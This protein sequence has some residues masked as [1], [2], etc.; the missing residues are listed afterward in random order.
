MQ[1]AQP[2]RSH[3]SRTISM[4]SMA[5]Y[6]SS[7]SALGAP[8]L[9][10]DIPKAPP[11]LVTPPSHAHGAFTPTHSASEALRYL[12]ATTKRGL[13]RKRRPVPDC[14][15]DSGYASSP[16]IPSFSRTAP[17]PGGSHSSAASS[18]TTLLDDG[19]CISSPDSMHPAKGL[20]AHVGGK[21]HQ[22]L[23]HK[24]APPSRPNQTLRNG[25][26]H[27]SHRQ[28]ES[29]MHPILARLER[30]S[31]VCAGVVCATC[32]CSGQGFP[33]CP[34][35]SQQWCSRECRMPGGKRHV[36]RSPA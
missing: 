15:Q 26:P 25:A 14:F 4:A 36:C 11:S 17:C 21:H 7:S 34:R 22:S 9:S 13:W 28:T 16:A 33:K 3:R 31:R 20:G 35:C 19:T 27:P 24:S 23:H 18:T 6:A 32:G 5:S 1:S 2:Y 30:E 10:I 12:H 8:K 29:D